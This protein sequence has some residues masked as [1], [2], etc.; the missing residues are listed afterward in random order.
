MD[1]VMSVIGYLSTTVIGIILICSAVKFIAYLENLSNEKDSKLLDFVSL[2]S[3]GFTIIFIVIFFVLFALSTISTTERRAEEKLEERAAQFNEESDSIFEDGF[4]TGYDE[5]YE[6]GYL[7]GYSKGEADGYD[8]G[9]DHGV[10]HAWEDSNVEAIEEYYESLCNMYGYLTYDMLYYPHLLNIYIVEGSSV[11]HIDWCCSNF[12]RTAEYNCI[13]GD[14]IPEAVTLCDICANSKT[15]YYLDEI[16]GI[17]HLSDSHLDLRTDDFITPSIT[18]R[19]VS[20]DAAIACG[21]AP[22]PECGKKVS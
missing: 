6:Y 10:A 19:L 7:E 22:C 11:Y 18:Y 12:D 5:G 20:Y 14:S 4:S 13:Y 16:A 9:Y 2:H 1:I 3:Y 17:F 21:Y 8:Q 15:Y